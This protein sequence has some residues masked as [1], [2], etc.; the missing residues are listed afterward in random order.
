MLTEFERTIDL[1]IG[2]EKVN[3]SESFFGFQS[4]LP[5]LVIVCTRLSFRSTDWDNVQHK[6]RQNAFLMYNLTVLLISRRR[7]TPE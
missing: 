3:D 2:Q 4:V 6:P 5:V 7:S 1:A